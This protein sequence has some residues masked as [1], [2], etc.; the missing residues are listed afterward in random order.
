LLA[1]TSQPASA[2]TPGPVTSSDFVEFPFVSPA[3][4]AAGDVYAIV[5]SS[6]S[7]FPVSAYTVGFSATDLYNGGTAWVDSGSGWF[8]FPSPLGRDL[9]F[10]TWVLTDDCSLGQDE[11]NDMDRDELEDAA[12]EAG[13]NKDD[14]IE[15]CDI[16]PDE[17][18][19]TEDEDE[20]DERQDERGRFLGGGVV[21]AFPHA[22]DAARAN[23]ARAAAA[24]PSPAPAIRPPSTGDAGLAD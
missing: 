14:L 21:G 20:A 4:I 5:A 1:S 22:A 19:E 16:D 9:A 11:S 17:L 13:R 6:S 18:D 8:A 12:D 23:R 2:F 3:S 24:T 7:P 15:L 10:K